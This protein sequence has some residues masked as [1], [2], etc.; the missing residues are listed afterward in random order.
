MISIKSIIARDFTDLERFDQPLADILKN[1][2]HGHQGANLRWPN[3]HFYFQDIYQHICQ[4]FCLY[5]KMLV[6]TSGMTKSPT[7]AYRAQL[8]VM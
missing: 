8:F 2:C 1:G 6:A 3:T 5:H 4:M 7:V